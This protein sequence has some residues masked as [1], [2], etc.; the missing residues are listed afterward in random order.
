MQSLQQH[1]KE[2]TKHMIKIL[3]IG[4]SFSQDA[5]AYLHDIATAGNIETK[6]GNLCIGGCSLSKHMENAQSDAQSYGYEINGAD[7]ERKISI[8]EALLEDD[9]DF[10]AMQQA[11]HDSGLEDSYF[12]HITQLSDYVKQYAPNAKQFI[13]QTWAYE[14]DSPHPAFEQY[15]NDQ[16]CM[17]AALKSAYEKAASAIGA[18][19]IPCGD[20]IQE[21][22]KQKPF[23]YANGGIS[24][25]CD[26]FHMNK[27]YG[28]YAIAATW[29]ERILKGAILENNF[30]LPDA[31]DA[32]I[33][34]V[35]QTI[36]SVCHHNTKHS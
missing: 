3:A 33:L 14:I 9:W 29:F 22:R 4:N 6:I 30:M 11:S 1:I 5:T 8:R 17:Y 2:R 12:P 23:D 7:M 27:I 10:V 13:H 34:L 28:R 24:L 31:D 16:L 21:L 32:A 20:V 18:D 25:C 35:K 26:G 36:H 15:Q 19:I